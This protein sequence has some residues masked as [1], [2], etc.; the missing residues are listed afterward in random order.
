MNQTI[1]NSGEAGPTIYPRTRF[2]RRDE[3]D[4]RLRALLERLRREAKVGLH[5]GCGTSRIEGMINCDLYAEGADRRLDAVE[6]GEVEDDSVDLIE[7]HHMIEHLSFAQ[8]DRAMS[9]W[10]RVL[11]P[12]GLLVVTCPNLDLVARRW[13]VDKYRRPFNYAV[14]K[15]LLRKKLN[16]FYDTRYDYTVQMFYGS[17][18]HDGMFHKSGYDPRQLAKLLARHGLH[19]EFVKTPYP[20]QP[21]PSLLL[22]AR[23]KA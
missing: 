18:E 19:T 20:Y 5:L 6:L 2:L 21:T 17:Q 8:A 16:P 3:V 14:K 11:K 9:E 4:K 10:A 13:L 23:K 12:G 1:R 15:Y 22:I 7:H